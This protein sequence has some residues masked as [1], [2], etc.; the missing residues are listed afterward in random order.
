M[1]HWVSD[2]WPI[3]EKP[4]HDVSSLSVTMSQKFFLLYIRCITFRTTEMHCLT[5]DIKKKE[6]EG[7]VITC[8]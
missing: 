3:F 8:N 1:D 6:C 2:Y 4:M 7:C 5:S